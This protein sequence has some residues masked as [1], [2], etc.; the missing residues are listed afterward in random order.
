MS[1]AVIVT[2][3]V[4]VPSAVALAVIMPAAVAAAISGALGNA[5]HAL[6]AAGGSAD[7]ASDDAP[8]DT[9]DR[10][11]NAGSGPGTFLRTAADALGMRSRWQ[12]DGERGGKCEKFEAHDVCPFVF[13]SGPNPF[14]GRLFPPDSLPCAQGCPGTYARLR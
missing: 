10:A 7:R 8:D 6:H 14:D 13:V 12:G 3:M 2:P 5:E 11:R 1:A 9:T 4:G